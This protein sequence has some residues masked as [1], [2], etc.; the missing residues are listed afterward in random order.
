V[1]ATPEQ[2]LQMLDGA[3]AGGFAYPSVNVTSTQ[4]LNAALR[5]FTE[6]DSDGIVQISVGGA[7]YFSGASIGNAV[8]GAAA[9]AEVAHVLAASHP[10][11]VGL[12]T[13]HCPPARVDSFLRPLLAMSQERVAGGGTPLFQSHMWDGSSLPLHENLRVAA[14]LLEECRRAHSVLELEIGVVGG[15]EDGITGAIDERLY[16]TP[17]DAL[18]VADALGLGERGRFLLA[19]TF[20][21]VHGVYQPGHVV[22]RPGV[23]KEIQDAVGSRHGR[24][25]PFYLVFHGGSG[26]SL[27]DIREAIGFGVVKMNVDTDAQYAFTR[28]IAD[29]VL[30]R[31]D[32]VLHVDGGTGDKAAYD[33]R[34]WGRAA[35]A[36]MADRVVQACRDLGSAGRRSARQVRPT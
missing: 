13:D 9:L 14:E 22:L 8:N 19:A 4:T 6:A 33:P 3:K 32:G 12:H 26:S 16:S 30:R 23:L 35:E 7:E 24:A 34:S 28:P 2:Y 27:D 29:H 36:S 20:G 17:D 10:G 18:R 31:Y 11:L 5:G 15:E 1:I 25:R 21:N